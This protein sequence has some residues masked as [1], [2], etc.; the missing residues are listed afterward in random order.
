MPFASALTRLE[1]QRILPIG[2]TEL[3]IAR[4]T[5][6]DDSYG[7]PAFDPAEGARLAGII[8]DKRVLMMANHGVATI[9]STV[10]EAYD[11]LYYTER[12]AQVQIYAMWTQRPL[13][14]LPQNVIDETLA[15]FASAPQY[16]GKKPHHWHFEALKRM[17]DKSEP[18]YK[19]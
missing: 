16:G 10:A 8:G 12:V 15:E 11:L 5:A 17:L 13:H 19:H 6:Y 3:A 1:D 2:Q 14:V 7:G 9:A 18:D 4:H